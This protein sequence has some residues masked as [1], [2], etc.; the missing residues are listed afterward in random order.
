MNFY[1]TTLSLFL[2]LSLG[3]CSGTKKSSGDNFGPK[4]KDRMAS[5]D[6]ALFHDDHNQRSPYEKQLGKGK[7]NKEVKMEAF[8]TRDFHSGKAF[9]GGDDKFK[10]AAFSQSDKTSNAANKTFSGADKQSALGNDEFKTSESRFSQQSNSNSDKLSPLGDDKF[11]T[12]N[13]REGTKAMENSKRPLI[14]PR[15][16]DGYSEGDIRKLL[17]KS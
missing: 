9:S 12:N 4:Y 8:K 5:A 17:N 1:F 6:R 13:D 3:A 16:E 7:K 2:M 10:T 14:A 15:N 11:R